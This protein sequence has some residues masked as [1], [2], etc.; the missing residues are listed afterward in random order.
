MTSDVNT[1]DF[2]SVQNG[3]VKAFER[4]FKTYYQRLCNYACVL[5]KDKNESEEVV[6]QVFI[7]I[8]NKR[9]V[10]EIETSLQS[11]LY[12]AVNNAG[13]NRLKQLNTQRAHRAQILYETAVNNES[14]SQTI[15]KD[16]L[17]KCLHSAVDRLPEQCRLTFQLSRFEGLKYQEIANELNVSVKTVENQVG[18]ALKFLRE[19]LKEFLPL[20]LFYLPSI[21]L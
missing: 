16:E 21:F 20:L 11:Y 3:D 6:Q 4:I 5:L 1:H 2:T 15:S 8:W 10:I 17:E 19:E 18:K 12:R 13:L 14:T 7:N 9:S